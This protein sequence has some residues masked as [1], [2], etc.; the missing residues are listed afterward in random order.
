MPLAS[1]SCDADITMNS[2]TEFFRWKQSKSGATWLFVMWCNWHWHHMM[3]MGPSMAPSGYINGITNGTIA[4]LAQDDWNDVQHGLFGHAM[5]L[6]MAL[7]PC[8]A[9]SVINGIIAF[10]R[11][12]WSKK[13]AT[14]LFGYVISL[15]SPSHNTDS[16]ISG[17][18]H[19][20]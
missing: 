2:A 10:L 7:A 3:L 6:A 11:S 4:V 5:P 14:W 9:V 18:W 15:P 12:R 13:V 8:D 1:V 20:C 19:Q 17:T 16:I